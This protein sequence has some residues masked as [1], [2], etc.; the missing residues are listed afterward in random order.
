[1]KLTLRRYLRLYGA[2]VRFSWS[3]AFEFRFDFW[4][5]V[6]MDLVFYAVNI[7]FFEI[8][9]LHS[10]TFGGLAKWQAL[11]FVATYLV[12]D[13]VRMT[14]FVNNFW[15]LRQM[16]AHGDFDFYVTKPASP[17]FLVTCREFS[18]ASLVNLTVAFGIL[19]YTFMQAPVTFSFWELAS[20]GLL[21]LNGIIITYLLQLFFAITVFWTKS[22]EG[23]EGVLYILKRFAERPHTIYHPVAR[24]ILLTIIPL[25]LV[26][27]A[28]ALSLFVEDGATLVM[29]SVF[30]SLFLIICGKY[31]WSSALRNY[32]S[33]SS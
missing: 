6:L 29:L 33:A 21:V 22:P 18:P 12:V 9:Y 24:F 27:S 3:R 8:L 17:L 15:M 26:A 11:I 2:L 31:A 13:G 10:P 16:V 7:V 5:R 14:F 30:I 1:M 4:L 25:G 32:T 28:P 20:Y 19:I 23:I